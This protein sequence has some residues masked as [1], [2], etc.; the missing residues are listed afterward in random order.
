VTCGEVAAT[1]VTFPAPAPSPHPPLLADAPALDAS[2]RSLVDSLPARLRDTAEK[3]PWTLGLTSS[4]GGSWGDFVRL[5]PNRELPVYAAQASDG[6]H[7]LRPA[8]LHRYVRAHHLGGF[9]WLLRDRLEDRQVAADPTLLELSELF[10]RRW[11][12]ALAEATGE[13]PLTDM[14]CRRSTALWRRGTGLEHRA[15]AAGNGRN[16]RNVQPL[17]PP[18]YAVLVREK[19]SWIAAPSQALLLTH[20]DPDR[21]EP[22]LAAHDLFLL[23]LQAIDDVIDRDQDRA[24]HG[25]DFPAALGCSPGALLRA[26]PKLVQRAAVAAEIGGFGWFAAWLHEFARAISTWSL[27]GAVM[28]DELDAIGIAGEIEEAVVGRGGQSLGVAPRVTAAAAP[29]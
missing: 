9:T 4:P 6:G 29:A 22:F 16:E 15:L 27:G 20:G 21:L 17:R 14:L 24:L 19:L 3:L 13:A 11:R 1:D 18:D 12:D 10:G 26:A 28:S 25:S 8:D 23:G 2:Y 5:H 7:C